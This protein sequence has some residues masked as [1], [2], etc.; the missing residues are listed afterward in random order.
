MADVEMS[1][2]E[3]RHPEIPL[4]NEEGN[5]R[6]GKIWVELNDGQDHKSELRRTMK[7]LRSK[8][9]KVK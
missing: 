9:R 7:E 3:E 6:D 2:E 4:N 5:L 8:L 1:A